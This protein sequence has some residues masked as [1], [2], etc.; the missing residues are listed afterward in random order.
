NT[1][2]AVAT[3]KL[4]TDIGVQLSVDDFGTGY[5]SLSYLKNLPIDTLKI[6]QSFVRDIVAG[7]SDHRVLARAIISIGHSLDLKVVAEGVETQAQAD[8]LKRH[9]CDEVQGYFYGHAVPA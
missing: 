9:Q 2:S 1:E 8:Y 3:L 4:L 5:S 7:K 6:D